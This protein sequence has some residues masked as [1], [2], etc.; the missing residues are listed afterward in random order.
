MINWI[1]KR[2]LRKAIAADVT[3]LVGDWV[4]QGN[5]NRD[6]LDKL[7]KLCWEQ[8]KLIKDM[9]IEMHKMQKQLDTAIKL[10]PILDLDKIL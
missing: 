9:T 2:W 5:A 4:E 10:P 8:S 6:A 3:N 1:Y 7:T